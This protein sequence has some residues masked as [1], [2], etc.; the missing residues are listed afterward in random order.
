MFSQLEG[1]INLPF[2]K[3]DIEKSKLEAKIIELEIDNKMLKSNV[4]SLRNELYSA[5][6]KLRNFEQ[7]SK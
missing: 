4:V 6:L 7:S 2:E 5:K 3:I 1:G